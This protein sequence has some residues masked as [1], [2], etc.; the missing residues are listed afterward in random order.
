MKPKRRQCSASFSAAWR[1]P[2]HDPSVVAHP[3]SEMDLVGR[4]R[5]PIRIGRGSPAHPVV[6]GPCVDRWIPDA[7]SGLG[8]DLHREGEGVRLQAQLAVAAEHLE[9]VEL[10]DADSGHEELPHSR[11]AHRAHRHQAPVPAI[12]VADDPNAARVRRPHAEA[13]AGRALVRARVRP[14]DVVEPLVRALGDQVQVDVPERRR[15]AIRV[16][17]LPGVAVGE[18]EADAIRELPGPQVRHEPRPQAVAH[19]LHR[20]DAAVRR[21]EPRGVGIGMEGANDRPVGG[22]VRAEDRVR[23]VVLTAREAG[24]LLARGRGVDR[25]HRR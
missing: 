20:R 6:I 8:S 9:L 12:E 14:E 18:A 10:A 2:S 25:R 13:D 17:E 24:G 19:G 15:E 22:R 23:V 16:V 5:G 3:R 4:H 7:R 21:D 11:G 1:Y